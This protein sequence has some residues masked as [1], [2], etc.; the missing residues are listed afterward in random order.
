[1]KKLFA[2]LLIIVPMCVVAQENPKYLAGAV[3]EDSTGLVVFKTTLE[4]EGKSKIAIYDSLAVWAANLAGEAI[5]GVRTRLIDQN[6]EQGLI[7]YRIEEWLVFKHHFLNF[8]R[9][10]FRYLLTLKCMD[11]KAEMAIS[12]ITYFY[13]EDENDRS[14]SF[15]KAEEWISDREALNKKQTKLYKYSAKFRRKTID[16]VEALQNS[17]KSCINAH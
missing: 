14:A 8:D 10:R 13:G 7:M 17:A 15:Y 16:R 2:L 6:P 11:G 12:H 1:M 9:T 4:A 5:E 3:P